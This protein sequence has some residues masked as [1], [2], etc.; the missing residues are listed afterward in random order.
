MDSLSQIVLGAACAAVL[1]PASER[2]RALLIG[3]ALG[4]LPDLDVLPLL[5]VADAVKF[6]TWHRTLTHSL[7]VLPLLGLALWWLAQ[8]RWA[9][10]RAERWR[11]LAGFE[12]ALI[13]HPLL[14]AHTVYGTQLLW[15][16][17]MPPAMWSTVFIIDPLYTLPLLVAAAGAW[18]WRER[19]S[20]RRV[21]V[22]GLLLS[23]AYLGWTWHAKHRVETGTKAMLAR[24][25]LER[26]PL[27]SVPTPFNSLG[28][29]IVVMQEDGYFEGFASALYPE[30][31]ITL[32]FH[33]QDVDFAR[34]FERLESVRRMRRFTQGFMAIERRATSTV[35]TDLRMGMAPDYFF[36]F[37]VARDLAG[38][39]TTVHPSER[40]P[41]PRF[42]AKA[43]AR[44]RASIV[45]AF[46]P[47]NAVVEEDKA[48]QA[49]R[50]PDATQAAERQ[51]DSASRSK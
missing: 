47:L 51:E 23:S 25:G 38:R 19:G 49:R 31:P 8:R 21:L 5:F 24:I 40:L 28:W 27:L 10:P 22:A 9:W 50:A 48:E 34:R 42:E 4:T 15:P 16:L 33:A 3:A 30:R 18:R 32:R 13:T 7:F 39:W 1:A 2:R 12:L 37:V 11:W 14:D 29:R 43:L 36:S 20:A 6:V 35:L 26:A 17:P 41:S 46:E 45:Q 44:V